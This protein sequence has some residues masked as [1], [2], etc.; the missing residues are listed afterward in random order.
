MLRACAWQRHSRAPV[1]VVCTE[2]SEHCPPR[3]V[4]PQHHWH[5]VCPCSPEETTLI[6]RMNGRPTGAG[7]HDRHARTALTAASVRL[8]LKTLRLTHARSS[9]LDTP[10]ARCRSHVDE[11]RP[12]SRLT[13]GVYCASGMRRVALCQCNVGLTLAVA[14]RPIAAGN[15]ANVAWFCEVN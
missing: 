14:G 9:E 7:A 15:V 8:T 2:A 1:V 10:P 6:R 13:L 3:S 5:A 12:T 11:W 4:R